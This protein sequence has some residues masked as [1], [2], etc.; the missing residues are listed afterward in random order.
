MPKG[1]PGRVLTSAEVTK[2]YQDKRRG[3]IREAKNRPCVDCGGSFPYWVMDLDHLEDKT[4]SFGKRGMNK[5][6]STLE[7]EIAKC[8]PVCSNCHRERTHA[9]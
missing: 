8:E 5:A 2:R 3:V 9:R 6:L 1:V 7:A 4:F